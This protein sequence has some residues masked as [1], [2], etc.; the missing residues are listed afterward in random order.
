LHFRVKHRANDV[1]DVQLLY[2][3]HSASIGLLMSTQPGT[4]QWQYQRRQA[5]D[6]PLQLRPILGF[7]KRD[8][9]ASLED[10]F[11]V[12]AA[13]NLSTNGDAPAAAREACLHG[14]NPRIGS[15]CSTWNE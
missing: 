1:L 6:Q 15:S 3:H 8:A 2:F 4:R 13:A 11:P 9:D 14:E 7:S 12:D 10:V 5:V